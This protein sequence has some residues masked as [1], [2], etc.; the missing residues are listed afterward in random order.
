MKNTWEAKRE[1]SRQK[2]TILCKVKKKFGRTDEA[3]GG[4]DV[5][6]AS[7]F[8]NGAFGKQ[9][10]EQLRII[11]TGLARCRHHKAVRQCL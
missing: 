7:E 11:V 9:F 3:H 4:D 10:L 6:S 1:K 8:F 5:A 2:C